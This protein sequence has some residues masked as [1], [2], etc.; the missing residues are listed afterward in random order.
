ML[1]GLANRPL[2]AAVA[3]TCIAG[4]SFAE[5]TYD[6]GRTHIFG[7]AHTT[8]E[9]VVISQSSTL[10]MDG[11]VA[12]MATV[13]NGEVHLINGGGVMGGGISAN[14]RSTVLVAGGSIHDGM[15]ID[16]SG[17]IFKTGEAYGGWLLTNAEANVSG[18]TIGS[19][20][21]A[22]TAH[23][24]SFISIT[25]GSLFLWDGIHA[26]GTSSVVWQGANLSSQVDALQLSDSATA[27]LTGGRIHAGLTQG[28]AAGIT[29]GD[30]SSLWIDGGVFR[31]DYGR[32]AI[33]VEGEG[34]LNMSGGLIEMYE[35]YSEAPTSGIVL[36]D[37]SSATFSGGGIVI[38]RY[39]STDGR[40]LIL[41][42]HASVIIVGRDFNFDFDTPIDIGWGTITGTLSDGTA[43]AWDFSRQSS[44]TIVLASVECDLDANDLCDVNDID[45]LIDSIASGTN[46]PLLDLNRDQEFDGQDIAAWV[47]SA[48]RTHF[49]DADLNGFFNSGDLVSVFQYGQ[50]EDGVLLNSSWATGDWTGDREFTTGDLVLAFQDGAYEQGDRTPAA[51]V[52]EPSAVLFAQVFGVAA[53][54]AVFRRVTRCDVVERKRQ[55]APEVAAETR[56]LKRSDGSDYGN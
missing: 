10:I 45:Y 32:T 20:F 14:D 21:E 33:L 31:R 6:D 17:V 12:G 13:N 54:L 7:P 16:N 1:C 2:H 11:G 37:H 26:T 49:G 30:E 29:L 40:H 38:H 55:R 47:Y 56:A 50:Y 52:P 53:A 36:K 43:I 15:R 48:R 28:A 41:E 18:G 46:Q 4:V 35:S 8:R 3:L 42:D 9:S 19:G 22:I 34:G 24:A 23:G 27:R 39:D 5:L 44:S 51:N 25:G